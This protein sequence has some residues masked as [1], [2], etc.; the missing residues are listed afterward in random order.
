MSLLAR[1]WSIEKGVSQ[2]TQRRY[3]NLKFHKLINHLDQSRK[4]RIE[5]IK[6][7]LIQIARLDKKIKGSLLVGSLTVVRTHSIIS[8]LFSIHSKEAQTNISHTYY[9]TS[10]GSLNQVAYRGITSL[11]MAIWW[12]KDSIS[13]VNR[14]LRYSR[15]NMFLNKECQC[16]NLHT[17]SLY[18]RANHLWL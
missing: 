18:S 2:R 16:L 11:I 6:Y 7:L 9:L 3:L 8:Q 15:H 13:I 12:M 5:L 1:Q 17:S 4:L 10:T 14:S